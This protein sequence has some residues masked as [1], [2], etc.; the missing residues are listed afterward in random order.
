MGGLS[1]TLADL[2][3]LAYQI[4]L[5]KYTALVG[6]TIWVWDILLT[7][8]EELE[9]LWARNGWLVKTLYLI[10]RGRY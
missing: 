7:F 9:L 6:A 10:V 2:P 3:K 5:S 4:R 8:P 1:F